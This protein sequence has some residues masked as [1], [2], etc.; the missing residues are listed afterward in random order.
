[1]R[2]CAILIYLL[3]FVH[4][5][6]FIRFHKR[7]ML[8]ARDRDSPKAQVGFLLGHSGVYAVNAV[9]ARDLGH[10]QEVDENLAAFNAIKVGRII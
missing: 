10:V 4:I 1:M 6:S 5:G 9:I 7:Q 2:N 3:D 8:K